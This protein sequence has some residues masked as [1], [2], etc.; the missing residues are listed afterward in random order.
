M[1]RYNEISLKPY[2]KTFEED[3]YLF[4]FIYKEIDILVAKNFNNFN[5]VKSKLSQQKLWAIK[6]YI[7]IINNNVIFLFTEETN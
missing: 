2:T 4:N 1:R 3:I 6:L 7:N 5:V